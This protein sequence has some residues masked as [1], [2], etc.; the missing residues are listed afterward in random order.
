VP[1]GIR[2][3]VTTEYTELLLAAAQK[4]K[5][6]SGAVEHLKQQLVTADGQLEEAQAEMIELAKGKDD[7]PPVTVRG[8]TVRVHKTLPPKPPAEEPTS[9][10]AQVEIHAADG[11]KKRKPSKAM[12]EVVQAVFFAGGEA[13]VTQV[14]ELLGMN[15]NAVTS[16]LVRAKG[17]GLLKSAGYGIYA[18]HSET[19]ERTGLSGSIPMG[20]MESKTIFGS[21][22]IVDDK[23]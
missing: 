23:N 15:A 11:K 1:Y 21:K 17:L 7:E 6:R 4:V 19:A 5:D 22:G 10:D 9:E 3:L 13:S 14:V 20:V 12:V 18:V 16:R 2:E 8:N